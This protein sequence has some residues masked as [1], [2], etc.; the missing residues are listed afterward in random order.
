MRL[1][2]IYN[3]KPAHKDLGVAAG[4]RRVNEFGPRYNAQTALEDSLYVPGSGALVFEF[5]GRPYF[6]STSP[7]VFF[8]FRYVPA[9]PV[10]Q[11]T[12]MCSARVG[13][14]SATRLNRRAWLP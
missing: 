10:I 8:D 9:T 13:W 7:R 5:G 11:P 12:D 3:P 2:L 4:H 14:Q 6:P 1:R